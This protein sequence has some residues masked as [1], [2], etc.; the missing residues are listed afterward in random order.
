VGGGGGGGVEEHRKIS[1]I[2]WKNV[3]LDK[4]HGDLGV[5]QMREFNITLLEKI[6]LEDAS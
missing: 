4:E 3:C 5:R 2:G 6:V 1:W